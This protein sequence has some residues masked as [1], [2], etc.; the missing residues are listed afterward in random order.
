MKRLRVCLLLFVAH[1]SASAFE[2]EHV[3]WYWKDASAFQHLVEFADPAGGERSVNRVVWRTDAAQRGGF[4]LV[5]H[6]ADELAQ[7]PAD[8]TVELSFL[9]DN[10]PPKPETIRFTLAETIGQGKELWMGLTG[11]RQPPLNTP[12]TAWRLRVYDPAGAM[13]VEKVSFVWGNPDID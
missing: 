10:G 6:C 3:S 12:L 13:L 5:A 9:R 8:T 2:V 11:D 4:Y 1:L 7:L